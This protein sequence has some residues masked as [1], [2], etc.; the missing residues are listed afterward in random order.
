VESPDALVETD[1]ENPVGSPDAPVETDRENPVESPDA[2][3]ETDRAHNLDTARRPRDPGRRDAQTRSEELLLGRYRPLQPLGTGGFGEVWRARDEL[4]HREVAVKRVPLAPGE[5]GERASREALAAARL[6]HP[7]IV[8]LYEACTVEDAF[9]LI[10]E[11]VHGKTLAQL[12]AE[13]ALSDEEILGI[14]VALADALAHAHSRGVIHRDVKPQNVLVP[15]PSD[16][17]AATQRESVGVAKLT[18]FG[19]ARL[20]GEDLTTRTGDVLGTL[21]YMAPEQSEGEEVGEAADLYS[22]ALVLYEALSGT[23]PVRGSTPAATARR[24]GCSIPPLER[25]RGDLPRALTRALDAALAPAPSDRGTLAHLRLAL[26][27]ARE[28]RLEPSRRL[29]RLG[30]SEIALD[31]G[32]PSARGTAQER[33]PV[34]LPRPPRGLDAR[35]V[36]APA[37]LPALL[38]IKAPDVSPLTGSVEVPPR[39]ASQL[40]PAAGAPP[41]REDRSVPA[42]EPE[43]EL[44]S[45]PARGTALSRVWLGCALA[46]IVWLAWSGQS[47]VALLALAAA[48]PLLGLLVNRP[49]EARSG[50]RLGP[51]PAR[52]AGPWWLLALVSPVLGI[53]GLAGAYPAIAGQA[54]QWRRRMA[55][56][57]LGYWWLTLAEPLADSGSAP[58]RLW[59]GEL[60]GTPARSVWEGSLSST[61]VHVIGPTLSLSVLSAAGIWAVGALVLPWLVRGRRA[62]LD[63]LAALAWSAAL[64]AA[65]CALVSGLSAHLLPAPRGVLAGAGLGAAL[66]VG[67]RALRGPV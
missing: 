57:A 51:A 13:R 54:R 18:D 17:G 63:L 8:A 64:T 35:V 4:L 12:L 21:A 19:G 10:S 45:A 56:G 20:A 62:A 41:N 27:E 33:P 11:L 16:N 49:R 9:Y 46:T 34:R 23:N 61:A 6:A 3:V 67:A 50:L 52:S 38:P 40:I 15:R 22:L 7:G 1:R 58:A 5:D 53:V 42:G 30:R 28:G 65:T 24:I 43:L 47:G 25:A 26:D 14:G 31:E 37:E 59:L 32:V 60:P 29:R 48:C 39:D 44:A 2:L 66:A 55:L 36:P